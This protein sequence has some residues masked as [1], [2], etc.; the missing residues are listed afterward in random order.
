MS[1]VFY[2]SDLHIGHRRVSELRGYGS[3]DQHDGVLGWK[4]DSDV[5]PDDTVWILG[6]ISINGGQ[7][8]L[9]WIAERPGHKVLVAG[10]HDPAQTVRLLLISSYRAPAKVASRFSRQGPF[11][12]PTSFGY[13]ASLGI[14][15]GYAPPPTQKARPDLPSDRAFFVHPQGLEP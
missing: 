12:V 11:A 13:T 4:W 2:T 6:D 9:D 5:R 14:Q 15:L 7:H 3:T 1:N 8:A 10:N